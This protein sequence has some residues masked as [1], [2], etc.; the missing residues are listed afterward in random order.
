[1]VK[2]TDRFF[3][4][5]L[6]GSTSFFIVSSIILGLMW[7]L[8]MAP[9]GKYSFVAA[10]ASIQYMDFFSYGKG[11]LQGDNSWSFT[12]NKGMGGNVFAVITY[13]LLSPF[14][15]LL[16]FFE[17]E[18][19][20]IFYD[21]IVCLKLAFAG[22]TMAIY[23]LYRFSGQL[24]KWIVIILSIGFGLMNYN[25]QQAMNVMWLDSVYMLPL[26]M[27]AL[28][29][30]RIDGQRLYLT[31]AIAMTIFFN[32][33]AG[34][35]SVMFLGIF[36]LWESIFVFQKDKVIWT[37]VL[38]FEI[39]V[40]SCILIAIGIDAFLFLPTLEALSG[41]RGGIDWYAL[42]LEFKK[43]LNIF[44]GLV[45]GSVSE[46]WQV[47][48]FTGDLATFGFCAFFLQKRSRLLYGGIILMVFCWLMFYFTPLFWLFSLL[49]DAS[50]YY[51]RYSYLASFS[52]IYMAALCFHHYRERR[53]EFEL[54]ASKL[55]LMLVFPVV[56]VVRQI[57]HPINNWENSLYALMMYVI[58]LVFF[59]GERKIS[60]YR[61]ICLCGLMI[62]LL[63]AITYNA[64][65]L[66]IHYYANTN[67][68][69]YHDYVVREKQMID[70]VK[71]NMNEFG[72]INDTAPYPM[73]ELHD[74]VNF[75]EGLAY[76]FPSISTYTSSPVNNQLKF[77]DN[78][79]YR[80]NGDNMYIVD[81]PVLGI[82]SLL[83]VK[84]V[85]SDLPI[86]SLEVICQDDSLKKK[87]YKNDF[88]MPIVFLCDD[89]EID[90]NNNEKNPFLYTNKIYETLLGVNGV[91][92]EISYA[93]KKNSSV[94]MEELLKKYGLKGKEAKYT[95]E[96]I[97]SNL[98]KSSSGA[99]YANIVNTNSGDGLAIVNDR[100]SYHLAGWCGNSVFYIPLDN[101]NEVSVCFASPDDNAINFQPQFYQLNEIA[102]KRA[103][104]KAKSRGPEFLEID[105]THIRLGIE[106]GAGEYVF[107]SI[108]YDKGWHVL[109]NGRE[110]LPQKVGGCF[111]GFVMEDG[112]NKFEMNYELPGL[113]RGVCITIISIIILIFCCYSNKK[114]SL[115]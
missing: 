28:Q 59:I 6:V 50:S 24:H 88:A 110:V 17:Q 105:D 11:L 35:F 73:N 14:N 57:T 5:F 19:F 41:G 111:M 76:G 85:I 84:Y 54:S 102:L 99:I 8:G 113:K 78:V 63:S 33:Y 49:K 47:S 83:G 22:S 37:E 3:P 30:M 115:L 12:F 36:S 91:Y 15:L 31:V 101:E 67:S 34:L 65:N 92:R 95:I 53:I 64:K 81:N 42:K 77:M 80:K 103:R 21:L 26:L 46:K 72:R 106:G 45:Y 7:Y 61:N 100:Y 112:Y 20:H 104:D 82:D 68:T 79:G 23:L 93:Q 38:G 4:Y 10:D 69:A 107:T 51:Y 27:I 29:K 108:P 58:L 87:I 86:E 48:L 109:Q 2:L 18:D 9:F 43:P 44:Q 71:N 94:K 62:L 90:I 40:V 16:L 97:L 39:K 66:L 96:Y 55:C 89:L 56:V 70:I 1:M 75:N 74:T 25:I 32:W 52:M 98:H 60:R 114:A 13:Y